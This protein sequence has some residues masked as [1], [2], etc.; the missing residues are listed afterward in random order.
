M[1]LPPPQWVANPAQ[2]YD[3][4]RAFFTTVVR[5]IGKCAL[6][7][8]EH[9]VSCSSISGAFLLISCV[10]GKALSKLAFLISYT[11]LHFAL[12][13][14]LVVMFLNGYFWSHA[15]LLQAVWCKISSSLLQ[16]NFPQL[17]SNP[18]LNF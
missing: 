11:E 12:V 10:F 16:C 5:C 3:L 8:S 4:F 18:F 7:F 9:R 1:S 14:G 15:Q 17:L 2:R 13:F 6:L